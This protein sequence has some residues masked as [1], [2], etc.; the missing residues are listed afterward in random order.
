MGTETPVEHRIT[1]ISLILD[2]EEEL[3]LKRHGCTVE[4]ETFTCKIILPDGA[5]RTLTEQDEWGRTCY[6]I[7]LPD[8]TRLTE[9]YFSDG[10][11]RFIFPEQTS[12]I[13]KIRSL[14]ERLRSLLGS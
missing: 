13:S 14:S 12:W 3:F 5:V 11:S 9:I 6:T 7:Q 8:K 4:I 10:K 1:L 2:T